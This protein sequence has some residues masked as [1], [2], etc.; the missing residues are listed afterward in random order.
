MSEDE[1]KVL[2][3]SSE[4]WNSFLMLEEIHGDYISEFR[5]HIHA[6]QNIILSRSV[7]RELAENKLK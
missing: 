3:I 5:F 7:L 4:L 6:L 1:K 2:N